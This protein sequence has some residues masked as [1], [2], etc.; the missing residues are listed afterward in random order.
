[1]GRCGS[2]IRAR[3]G[4]ERLVRGATRVIALSPGIQSGV[5]AAGAPA[6]RVS[7]V[8]NAS[9]LDLFRPAPL[10]KR[11][12]V[13]YFGTMGEANDLAPVV[14]A[15]RLLDGVDFVLM[16]DGKHRARL[17]SSA[18]PNVTFTGTAAGKQE[19]AELAAS[20]SACNGVQGRTRAGTTR[21][22]SCSTP[23]PPDAR[24][25]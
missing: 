15:A 21:P 20:S 10:P 7:L 4:A 13:S 16:G 5:V 3:R 18:P 11:F 19:V 2:L 8:P 6:E 17:E 23:S 9:D 22:T 24:R 25:S 14:E 12:R 1:M